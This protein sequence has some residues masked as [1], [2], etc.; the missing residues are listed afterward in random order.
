MPDFTPPEMLAPFVA[1]RRLS[2]ARRAQ[3][4]AAAQICFV[5]PG[6]AAPPLNSAQRCGIARGALQQGELALLPGAWLTPGKAALARD[7]S[8]LLLWDAAA[9][10]AAEA[11][12]PT[13]SVLADLAHVGAA[14]VVSL[15]AW[16]AGNLV[17]RGLP[18]SRLGWAV[19]VL[20]LL[21]SAGLAAPAAATEPVSP[22]L[23]PPAWYPLSALLPMAILLGQMSLP[24]LGASLVLLSLVRLAR[25]LGGLPPGVAAGT[26]PS[27]AVALLLT[28]L[29][30]LLLTGLAL[31]VQRAHWRLGA[32]F[33]AVLLSPAALAAGL[34]LGRRAPGAGRAA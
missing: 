4:L 34:A 17:D 16:I 23:P 5:A 22:A 9:M 28:G 10:P 6:A 15:L 3:L 14:A 30:L 29:G 1:L 2:A 21:P 12:P 26:S 32:A 7:P 11:G 31:G 25:D 13:A 18:S 8:L 24:L 19:L 27:P 20:G 33:T